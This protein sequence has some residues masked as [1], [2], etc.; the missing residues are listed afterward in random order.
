M[1]PKLRI[2]PE[3]SYFEYMEDIQNSVMTTKNTFW[4]FFQAMFP[5]MADTEPLL[6][7]Q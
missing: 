3:V 6:H 1:F 4:N 2:S 7:K 5:G